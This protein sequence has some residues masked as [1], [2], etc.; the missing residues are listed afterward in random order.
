[1]RAFK[2]RRQV[3]EGVAPAARAAARSRAC[4]SPFAHA[5]LKPMPR[6]PALDA[7]SAA[8]RG[9]PVMLCVLL[10]CCYG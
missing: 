3:A 1:M 10:S 6:L 2:T 7:A 4:C 8:A 5:H 9:G